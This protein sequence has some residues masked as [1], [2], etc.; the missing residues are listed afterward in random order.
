MCGSASLSGRRA[1]TKNSPPLR[2][3]EQR[4]GQ[5]KPLYFEKT[6]LECCGHASTG[7]PQRANRHHAGSEPEQIVGAVGPES[8][9]RAPDCILRKADEVPCAA[10]VAFAAAIAGHVKAMVL[11]V[12][13]LIE[14]PMRPDGAGMIQLASLLWGSGARPVFLRLNSAASPFSRGG[15][16]SI[17]CRSLR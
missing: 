10:V 1:S 17:A 5:F 3:V 8:I 11:A 12:S 6:H 15:G 7:L 16:V 2:G 14:A 13:R 9:G 4:A